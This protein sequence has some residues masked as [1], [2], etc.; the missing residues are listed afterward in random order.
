MTDVASGHKTT[1]NMLKQ[2]IGEDS[3]K[4]FANGALCAVDEHSWTDGRR[5]PKQPGNTSCP[6]RYALRSSAS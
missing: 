6:E 1:L 5:A 4:V 3:D 2:A